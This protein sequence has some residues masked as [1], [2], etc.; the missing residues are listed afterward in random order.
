MAMAILPHTCPD[1][2]ME[3]LNAAVALYGSLKQAE[4]ALE[5]LRSAHFPMA[6]L[7]LA[8][9]QLNH[10]DLGHSSEG[11]PASKLGSRWAR[12]EELLSGAALFGEADQTYIAVLG[13]LVAWIA[14]E[15]NAGASPQGD[16]AFGLG[17][18]GV[19]IP[20]EMV[21]SYETAVSRN[22]LVLIGHGTVTE[23]AA[24]ERFLWRTRPL[25][26][27]QYVAAPSA[28]VAGRSIW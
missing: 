4:Q 19:G 14:T 25:Q 28:M 27:D 3:R 20:W 24:A 10:D 11:S 9:R 13:P 12:C 23:A 6:Q 17:M 26:L 16:T 7:S 2:H 22:Q 21:L 18:T 1:L 8:G 15:R 5:I